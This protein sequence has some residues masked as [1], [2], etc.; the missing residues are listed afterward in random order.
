VYARSNLIS[1][2]DALARMDRFGYQL[3]GVFHS[4]PGTGKGSVLPS[5][6]DEKNQRKLEQ[7]GYRCIS[8]IFSRDGW[9]RFFTLNNPFK[10]AVKG[11]GVEHVEENLFRLTEHRDVQKPQN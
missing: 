8:G 5:G 11:K 10:V 4:H 1:T 2:R 7:A 3:T 6:T 9:I